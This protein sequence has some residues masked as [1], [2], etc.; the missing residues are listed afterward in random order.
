M[1]NEA[2]D[3]SSDI[4]ARQRRAPGQAQSLMLLGQQRDGG[5]VEPVIA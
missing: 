4:R 2:A 5:V 1:I 3:E